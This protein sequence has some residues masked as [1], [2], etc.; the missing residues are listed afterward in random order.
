MQKVGSGCK[1]RWAPLVA[2]LVKNPPAIGETD[3][4]SLACPQ[5]TSCCVAQGLGTLSQDIGKFI[6]L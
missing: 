6:S 3:E 2:Q 1:Y 5:L 4:V